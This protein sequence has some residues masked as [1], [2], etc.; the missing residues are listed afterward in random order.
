MM[1]FGCP[2]S[3]ENLPVVRSILRRLMPEGF[4]VLNSG[5]SLHSYGL[6]LQPESDLLAF[7]GKALLFAPVVDRAYVAHRL[8]DA[9]FSLRVCGGLLGKPDPVALLVEGDVLS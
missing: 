6:V 3:E 8:I 2:P 5:R 1:D 7:A 9:Q 4:V